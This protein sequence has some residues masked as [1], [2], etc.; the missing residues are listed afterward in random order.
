M[1]NVTN[2]EVQAPQAKFTDPF[3]FD[4]SFECIGPLKEGMVAIFFFLFSVFSPL[5]YASL[6]MY[7]LILDLEWN[8]IYVGSAESAQY[9]QKLESILVGPIPVG[10]NRF[11]FQVHTIILRMR[12]SLIN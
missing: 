7:I 9:D 5:C 8:I 1:I 4:I 10:N 11:T 3:A 12:K 2:V 6:L